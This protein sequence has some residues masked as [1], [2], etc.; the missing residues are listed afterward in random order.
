MKRSI[1]RTALFCLA[2]FASLCMVVTGQTNTRILYPSANILPVEIT[3]QVVRWERAMKDSSSLGLLRHLYSLG[4]LEARIDS[5]AIQGDERRIYL[6]PGPQYRWGELYYSGAGEDLLR[7]AGI[8]PSSFTGK[9]VDYMEWT[10]R[11]DLLLDELANHGYPF[12]RVRL[13]TVIF[14]QHRINGWLQVEKDDYFSFD[15]LVIRG[16]LRISGRFMQRYLDM[17]TGNPYSEETLSRI[18]VRLGSLSYVTMTRSPEPEFRPGKVDLYLTLDRRKANRV[19]GMLGILPSGKNGKVIFTGEA[20]LYLINAFA[21]GEALDLRW[22]GLESATQE[23]KTA[24]SLPFLLSSPLGLDAS[25]NL[26]KRDTSYLTLDGR[27]GLQWMRRGGSVYQA[28]YRWKSST[29]VSTPISSLPSVSDGMEEVH[30][31]LY[32]I[33]VHQAMLDNIQNPYRGYQFSLNAGAGLRSVRNLPEEDTITLRRTT[34]IET[35]GLAEG[36]IPFGKRTTLLLRGQAGYRIAYAGKEGRIPLYVNELFRIGGF[37]SIRGFAEDSYV[38]DLFLIPTAE[39]RYLF[40]QN[41]NFHLFFDAAYLENE[42]EGH[43]QAVK[44][45]GFGAGLQLETRAGI[46]S[47]DYA[48]GK[49]QGIPLSLRAAVIHLGYISVF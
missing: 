4:Y 12:A 31:G 40:Q 43:R 24:I 33:G 47:L 28:W 22:R 26:Y 5:Q 23:L 14:E 10:R 1:L 2:W 11:G 9:P 37:H 8:S 7:S 36:F 42:Q 17:I 41:S 18:P 20:D 34:G 35:E 16:N 48:A 39:L 45:A 49:E 27:I 6:T 15:S 38:A 25:F 32:G 29:Q 3:R 30:Q 21:H 46:L 19:N 13:D 44:L